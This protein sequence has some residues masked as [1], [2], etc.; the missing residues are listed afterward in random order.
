M[1]F[2]PLL[3]VVPIAFLASVGI[4]ALLARWSR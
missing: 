2:I 1:N 3:L 4:G